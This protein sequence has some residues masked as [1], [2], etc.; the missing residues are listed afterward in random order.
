MLVRTIGGHLIM[1]SKHLRFVGI[2]LDQRL[3]FAKHVDMVAKIASRSTL[4][5]ALLVPNISGP[6][7]RKR[8]LFCSVVESQYTPPLCGLTL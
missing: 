8:I 3:M 4:A 7:Y 1:M 6:S 5:L 2:I